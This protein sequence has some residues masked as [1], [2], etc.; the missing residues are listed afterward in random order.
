MKYLLMIYANEGFEAQQTE[1]WEEQLINRYNALVEKLQKQN[2]YL[3]GRRLTPTD[4]ATSVQ[5][6]N[7]ETLVSDGPFAE[8]KEQLGGFFMVDCQDLDHASEIAA[9]IPSAEYGTIEI[10]PLW[11]QD[12]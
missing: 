2:V 9:M 10:R 5:V 7:G 3:D 6:R 11:Y 1:A 8:T 12:E 4:T